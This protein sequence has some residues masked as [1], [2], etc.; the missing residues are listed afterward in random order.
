MSKTYRRVVIIVLFSQL[1]SWRQDSIYDHDNFIG[2]LQWVDGER[3][4]HQFPFFLLFLE[5]VDRDVLERFFS[6][7][8]FFSLQSSESSRRPSWLVGGVS[9]IFGLVHPLKTPCR[10]YIRALKHAKINIHDSKSLMIVPKLIFVFYTTRKRLVLL[11]WDMKQTT[12]HE[13][14]KLSLIHKHCT[15]V[16]SFNHFLLGP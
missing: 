1:E 13:I 6:F 12:H 7:L 3:K 2:S 14:I 15:R 8:M 9:H 5:H 11:A 16:C 4:L 10:L